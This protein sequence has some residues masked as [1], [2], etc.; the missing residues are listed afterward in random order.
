MNRE[1][2][3]EQI[4]KERIRQDELHPN[5]ELNDYLKI[6]IEEVGEVGAALQGEGDLLEELVQ[7]AAVVLRWIE[8]LNYNKDN[9]SE[10]TVICNTC[11]SK[12]IDVYQTWQDDIIIHCNSCGEHEEV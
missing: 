8:E 9:A 1:E 12:D 6:L 10:F 4:I 2:I 5:N 3:L 7:V 11:R